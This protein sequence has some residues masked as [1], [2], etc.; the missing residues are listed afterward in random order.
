MADEGNNINNKKE[1]IMPEKKQIAYEHYPEYTVT[2]GRDAGALRSARLV[3]NES[4]I[5]NRVTIMLNGVP[6]NRARRQ[7]VVGKVTFFAGQK[8]E[9]GLL[10]L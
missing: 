4:D 9:T 1:I 6:Y 2:S 5:D 3:L 8:P 10:E 7:T